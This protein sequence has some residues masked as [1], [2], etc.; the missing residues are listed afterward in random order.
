[1]SAKLQRLPYP[2]IR[3]LVNSGLSLS[4]LGM[5]PHGSPLTEKVITCQ[6]TRIS[7]L[8]LITLQVHL[9]YGVR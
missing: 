3:H 9:F 5:R 7:N 2:F 8:S 1:M 6:V 4:Y